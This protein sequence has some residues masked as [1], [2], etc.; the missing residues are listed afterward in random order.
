[1]FS[2]ASFTMYTYSRIFY[3]K[4][5]FNSAK[6]IVIAEF[7][8]LQVELLQSNCDSSVVDASFLVGAKRLPIVIL[9]LMSLGFYYLS[10]V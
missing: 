6:V 10:I 1:M 2:Q 5:C 3:N 9:S 7:I 4:F 8:V